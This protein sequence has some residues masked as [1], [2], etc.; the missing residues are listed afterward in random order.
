VQVDA[1]GI[2]KMDAGEGVPYDLLGFLSIG[3][4]GVP[5]KNERCHR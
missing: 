5:V 2:G 3:I 1:L 4:L